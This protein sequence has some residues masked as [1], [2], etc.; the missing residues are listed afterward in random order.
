[1]KFRK[2]TAAA[3][4]AAL[5]VTSVSMPVFARV[6]EKK[7]DYVAL[8]DS[9]AAGFGLSSSGSAELLLTDPA[10]IL[11]EDL[12]A[13]PVQDAYAAVF[14]RYLAEIGEKYGYE[15]T[16]TNLSSTAYRAVDVADTILNNPN[17]KGEYKGEVAAWILDTF[18]GEGGS[19]PLLKYHDIY[20]KY[21]SE[22]ELVSIQLGGND[23][24]MNILYPILGMDN[25]VMMGI[26][27]SLMLTLFGCDTTTALGGGLQYMMQHSDELTYEKLTETAEYFMNVGSNGEYYVNIAAEQVADVVDAVKQV[28]DT[29]DIVLVGMFNPY[30]NSLVYEGQVRDMANIMTNIFA[31]AAE[32]V[33]DKTIATD[34]VEIPADE[35]IADKTDDFNNDVAALSKFSAKIKKFT[36]S[37]KAK[38]TRLVSAVANEISYPLLY[39]TAGNNVDPQM[40]LLNQKLKALADK[41]GSTYVDVYDINNE[42]NLDPH[43]TA[44]G[45]KEI[46]DIMKTELSGMV[47]QRMSENAVPAA[48]KVTVS[49]SAVTITAGNT[50][51]LGVTVAPFN[52]S[53]SVKWKSSNPNVASVDSRGVVVAKKAGT[54]T[55]TATAEN[56]KKAVCKVTVNKK[57]SLLQTI[58][59]T[60]L[61]K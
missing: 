43:P 7:Y 12:I 9:I 28:N 42:C 11:T 58:L 40:T 32:I 3:L 23:I 1:M 24:V 30:G 17:S 61:K 33:C 34:E 29:A 57:P 47:N 52:A 15:T 49:K 36:G 37:A 13:N 53:Q 31:Q 44:N 26:A 20:D 50:Y 10:L 6:G 19:E 8:G 2:I 60:F 16:A 45:H 55:I 54:A 22:A 59:K 56:G 4:S 48:E 27:L 41:T 46:A 5:T 38:F 35:E 21:L 25:P 51:K 18:V 39:M 14:G